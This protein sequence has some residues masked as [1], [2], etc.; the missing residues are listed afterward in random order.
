MQK[1]LI[2]GYGEVGRALHKIIGG[3]IHDPMKQLFAN[4]KYDVMHVCIPFFDNFVGEMRQYKRLFKPNLVIIH[5]TVPIGTSKR[6]G[7]VHSP[8][9][10]VH[11]Q[12]EKG[13]RT[14][15]KYFGGKEA[16]KAANLFKKYG[17]LVKVVQKSETT[18]A[19][20]LWDTTQYGSFI[21][22]NKEIKTWCEKNMVDFDIV[23]R[24][25]NET[26]NIGYSKLGMSHVK[27][28]ALKFVKGPIGGHCVLQNAKLLDSE[29]ARRLDKSS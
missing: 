10:G 5:S 14:F 8:I 27:R 6:L 23:Y 3:D 19:A 13:I 4:G 29:T 18:E 12:L 9:R 26:Y 25:F 16:K 17:I 1:N 20:K 22:L 24:D 2:I 15:V 11:P 28:P 21:L 7:A